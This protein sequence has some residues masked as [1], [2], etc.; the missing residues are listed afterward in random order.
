MRARRYEERKLAGAAKED[1]EEEIRFI[2]NSSLS[3]MNV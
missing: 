2:A 1:I 3:C